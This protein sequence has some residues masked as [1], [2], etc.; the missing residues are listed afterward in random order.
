MGH[1]WENSWSFVVGRWSLSVTS[2]LIIHHFPLTVKTQ[3]CSPGGGVR[4]VRLV[5]G[6]AGLE[7][8]FNRRIGKVAERFDQRTEKFESRGLPER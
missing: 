2:P 4:R 8:G 7:T 3:Q 1:G 6:F 5:Q